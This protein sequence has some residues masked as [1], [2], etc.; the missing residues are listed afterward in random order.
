[1]MRFLWCLLEE[2]LQKEEFDLPFRSPHVSNLVS[3]YA[4]IGTHRD[5]ELGQRRNWVQVQSLGDK[6]AVH[7]HAI[8]ELCFRSRDAI[9]DN[10]L[11]LDL[12][13]LLGQDLE[14]WKMGVLQGGVKKE[15]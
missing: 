12:I 4:R 8:V 2:D 15:R 1:M 6:T 11:W 13:S 3:D 9:L 5:F 7:C 10:Y 14:H